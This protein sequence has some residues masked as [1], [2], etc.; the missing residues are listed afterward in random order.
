M[1]AETHSNFAD[2]D[3]DDIVDYIVH[4]VTQLDDVPAPEE[5]TLAF[6]GFTDGPQIDLLARIVGEE[7]GERTLVGQILDEI[8]PEWLVVD[9]VTALYPGLD[10]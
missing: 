10:G 7:F 3:V 9:F 8:E 5:L 2:L 4:V 1:V 6:C